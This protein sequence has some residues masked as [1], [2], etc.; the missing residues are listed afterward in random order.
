M[1]LTITLG[2]AI[3]DRAMARLG[4]VQ[5][6]LLVGLLVAFFAAVGIFG[7]GLMAHEALDSERARLD[8]IATLEAREVDVWLAEQIDDITA[9]AQNAVFR[10]LLTPTRLRSAGLWTERLSA[11]ADA[12]RV[13]GWLQHSL[14]IHHYRSIEVVDIRGR[15]LISAG[16]AGY[17]PTAILPLLQ[18]ARAQQRPV[19]RDLEI[20]GDGKAVLLI[21][22]AVPEVQGMEPVVLVFAIDIFRELLPRLER[23]PNT[24]VTGDLVLFRPQGDAVEMIS[25][26]LVEGRFARLAS[27]DARAPAVQALRHG[28]GLYEGV[29]HRGQEVVAAVRRTALL[30]WLVSAR[31]GTDELKAP[32]RR[33]ALLCSLLA[34]A[35]TLVAGLFLLLFWRS[36]HQRLGE[37][38]G[39]NEQ[40]RQSSLEAQRATRSKSAFLANMSHEIRTPLNAIVGLTHLLRSRVPSASWEGERLT[41]ISVSARHLLTVINDVLDISRIESGRLQ[42]E[43]TDFLL[44]EVVRE[45]V[46]NIT[47]QRAREKGLELVIDIDEELRQPLRGDP[48]RL[49]QA[50]LNYVGNAI[51]FTERGR[52]VIDAHVVDRDATGVLAK[53]QVSDTGVGMTAEQCGRIFQA[54]EQAD[55][56][57]TRKYGGSGLGLAI[58]RQ[59]AQLMGGEVGVESTQGAGSTFWFTARLGRGAPRAQR[60][61]PSLRGLHVL[62]ADDQPEAR[63]VHVALAR[64]LGMRP[65]EAADGEQALQALMGADAVGDPYRLLLLDWHMPRLDGLQTLGRLPGL[66]LKSQPEVLVVTGD[67]HSAIVEQARNAGC[68]NVLP[69]PLTASALVDALADL[70]GAGDGTPQG[71]DPASD[72]DLLAQLQGRRIL[73]AE[74]NPV[75][76]IVM[77]ELLKAIGLSPDLAVDGAEAVDMA[78][79]T[80]YDLVLMDMQMPRLDGLEATRRIRALPGWADVPILAMTANA[81]REDREA[82]LA[83]GMNDH[84]S[85]P[86]E[87][88]RLLPVLALW[89]GADPRPRPAP[90]ASPPTAAPGAPA[91]EAAL[92]LRRLQ[93]TMGDRPQLLQSLVRQFISMH[94]DDAGRLQRLIDAGDLQ[95]GFALAHTLKGS[96]AELGAQALATAARAL[97]ARLR[98][99]LP[100][101]PGQLQALADALTATGADAEHWLQSQKAAS[102]PTPEPLDG[103]A[104]LSQMRDLMG[105]LDQVDGRALTLADELQGRLPSGLSDTTRSRVGSVMAAVQ[106]LD[107][108]HAARALRQA[109][110]D[111]EKELK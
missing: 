79:R 64:R 39:L 43:N 108:D 46:F 110:P 10:E 52:I 14:D 63:Q 44:D 21:A 78:S 103:P 72:P 23:W 86:V 12:Y 90:P 92:D 77:T 4:T 32:M 104:F 93:D 1:H 111:I 6:W 41:Q 100:P 81:F 91:S 83:A 105:L 75:N 85:K 19:F 27:N 48:L 101:E 106:Q 8:S 15:S 29:D 47:C 5:A 94:S 54:F 3:L 73:L 16:R 38:Q 82:C 74:D 22:A 84:L 109:L 33:L 40:L 20:D 70:Q 26:P 58:A 60:A 97:E 28:D 65:F 34:G 96:A 99:G 66:L 7:F 24:A 62:V 87:P 2:L 9:L 59:L 71:A 36:Q 76:R 102:P 56:S 67:E 37:A 45:K 42:L 30:P 50:L 88:D 89:L 68:A 69:K 57:T 80:V 31:I 98:A 55:S 53:L 11:W 95:R 61:L 13:S 25:K 49:A 51:K 107:L 18:Q 17:T 35:G